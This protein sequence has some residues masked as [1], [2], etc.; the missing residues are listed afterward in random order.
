[1]Y[2]RH[3]DEK[4]EYTV[5]QLD[6][7]RGFVK[8]KSEIESIAAVVTFNTDHPGITGHFASCY[9]WGKVKNK[10]F[11]THAGSETSSSG[12]PAITITGG[13]V[14][15]GYNLYVSKSFSVTSYVEGMLSIAKWEP[16]NEKRGIL[17]CKLSESNECI[18]EKSI[19]LR[20]NWRFSENVVLQTWISGISGNQTSTNVSLQPLVAP[21]KRYKVSVPIKSKN[22]L[23]SECGLTYISKVTESFSTGTAVLCS[24]SK[25][26]KLYNQQVSA[27]ITYVF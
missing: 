7:G 2:S 22:Y 27:Y 24:F 21:I 1:M 10:R 6:E 17:L 5:M 4:K 11:F 12:S 20:S 18:F 26:Q 9:G 23:R 14:Q 25:T 8:A 15:V 16:Y 3:N 19:G 13:L